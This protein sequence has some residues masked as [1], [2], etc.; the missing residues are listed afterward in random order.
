MFVGIILYKEILLLSSHFRARILFAYSPD[1]EIKDTRV[2][3]T[4]GWCKENNKLR[5]FVN[6]CCLPNRL[7]WVL[8]CRLIDT[9]LWTSCA[10]AFSLTCIRLGKPYKRISRWSWT[11]QGFP[12]KGK[13]IARAK[14]QL[15]YPL[16]CMHWNRKTPMFPF[17]E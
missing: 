4:R 5:K 6:I 1:R 15:Q 2:F 9:Q 12:P 8:L 16:F 14:R 17:F 3:V 7:K 10:S 11:P 13:R